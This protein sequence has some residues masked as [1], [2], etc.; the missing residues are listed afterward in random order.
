MIR[1]VIFNGGFHT[2][3]LEGNGKTVKMRGELFGIGQGTSNMASG[4][5]KRSKGTMT[6]PLSFLAY[7]LII[8]YFTYYAGKI[9]WMLLARRLVPANYRLCMLQGVRSR[10]TWVDHSLARALWRYH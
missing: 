2:A 10:L 3:S 9:L 7:L 1:E 4:R 6:G 8:I 5:E